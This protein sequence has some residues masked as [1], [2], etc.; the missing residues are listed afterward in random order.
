MP[1]KKKTKSRGRRR[2]RITSK[3]ASSSAPP[4]TVVNLAKGL[5]AIARHLPNPTDES[6]DF[7]RS[8]SAAHPSASVD[9]ATL[10]Q[11]LSVGKRYTIDLSSADDFFTNAGDTDNWGD[12]ARGF[13]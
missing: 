8:F 13:Q 6:T 3:A 4:A 2:Q 12:D 7:F 10:H 5:A 1:A 9:S 11:S